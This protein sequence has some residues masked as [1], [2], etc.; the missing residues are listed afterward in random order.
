MTVITISRQL[1]T[2]GEEIASRVAQ[3]L[4]LRLI[5]AATINRA[6]QRAGVPQMALAELE[7]EGERG[8]ANQMLKALRTMPSLR[9]SVSFAV[10]VAT[11]ESAA[12]PSISPLTI[13]FAGLFSPTVPPISASLESYVRMVGLVIRGLAHEGNVLLVGR[14][15]QVLLKNHP[16]ALHVQI[17]A[18]LVYRVHVVMERTELDRRAAQSRVR[19][20]DRA[21]FDYL[22][23]YH[24]VDWLDPTL[25]H[26][27]LNTGRMSIAMAAD[28]II[29]AQQAAS[30][31]AD[32]NEVGE[33]N[34]EHV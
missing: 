6:A 29:A 32:S 2:H 7:H 3:A 13:P 24:D 33:T 30:Q 25:Y 1:G 12:A 8:L 34:E 11:E 17:V 9:S 4:Q 22:R 15:A 19:A 27:V 20:S 26:L 21:R 14:G 18:P 16:G 28:L 5:D 23:R 10:P 31:R